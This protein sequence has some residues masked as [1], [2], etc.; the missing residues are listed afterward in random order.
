MNKDQEQTSDSGDTSKENA[1]MKVFLIDILQEL[2][3]L[4]SVIYD[5]KCVP[6][7]RSAQKIN[8]KIVAKVKEL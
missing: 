8:D 4:K 7:Y 5:G 1:D 3:A 2:V 6:A